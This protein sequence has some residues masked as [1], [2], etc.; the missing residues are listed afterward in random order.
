MFSYVLLDHHIRRSGWRFY[1]LCFCSVRSS[2]NIPFFFFLW[3]FLF[4]FLF[5]GLGALVLL[6]LLGKPQQS[7][8]KKTILRQLYRDH[9]ARVQPKILANL[10]FY[11]K[12]S[13]IWAKPRKFAKIH[14]LKKTQKNLRNFTNAAI[15]THQPKA[16]F[17]TLGHQKTLF[18]PVFFDATDRGLQNIR[19]HPKN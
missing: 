10:V 19:P 2:F 11:G 4:F 8:T 17:S 3:F 14:N 15:Q 6:L 12:Y 16:V 9:V 13:L 5:F 1:L 7:E 18:F